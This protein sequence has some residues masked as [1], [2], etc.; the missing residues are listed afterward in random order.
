L[1]PVEIAK[2]Y[3]EILQLRMAIQ[4]A[5]LA[6]RNSAHSRRHRSRRDVRGLRPTDRQPNLPERGQ[7]PL[8]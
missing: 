5:E 3:A 8:T 6:L 4:E 7:N 2:A 1:I